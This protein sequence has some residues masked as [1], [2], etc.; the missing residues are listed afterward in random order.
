MCLM[1]IST[2]NPIPTVS[3][4]A[5]GVTLKIIG[6]QVKI[7]LLF[8]VSD[9]KRCH[10]ETTITLSLWKWLLHLAFYYVSKT[11]KKSKNTLKIKHK[12]P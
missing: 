7:Y 1:P 5:F 2:S 4:S 11:L 3:R 9:I 12:D 10:S 6:Y 8:E